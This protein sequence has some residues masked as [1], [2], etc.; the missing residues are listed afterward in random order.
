MA[1]VCA[2]HVLSIRQ[3]PFFHQDFP[4]L[5]WRVID[6]QDQFYG[7]G[8]VES[9]EHHQYALN[10]LLNQSLDAVVFQTNHIVVVNTAQLA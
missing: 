1:V 5:V 7:Q 3:N 6:V 2:D 4:Y 10:A 8:L 9:V